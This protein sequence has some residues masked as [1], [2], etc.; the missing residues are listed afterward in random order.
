MELSQHSVLLHSV[1][2]LLTGFAVMFG[3][4]FTTTMALM[5]GCPRWVGTPGRPSP[6]YVL[7]NMA[8]CF[9]G[10]VA[11]GFMTAMIAAADPLRTVLVLAVIVLVMSALSALECRG[12]QPIRYQIFLAVLG[13]IGVVFGGI[14]RLKLVSLF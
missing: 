3:I 12:R 8:Y 7:V 6:A 11:G 14:L 2:A 1:L 9:V 5:K 10:A 4:V 13:P